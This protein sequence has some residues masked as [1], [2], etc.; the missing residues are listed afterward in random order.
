MVSFITSKTTGDTV[1]PSEWNQT[2]DINNLV[3]QSGITP[4]TG[5]LTQIGQAVSKYAAIST[6]YT[7]SGTAN[8]YVLTSI[9]SFESS[10][11]YTNGMIIRFRAANANTGAST[12]NVSGLGVVNI[13]KSDGSTDPEANDINTNFDTYARYDGTAFRLTSPNEIGNLNVA[14][15]VNFASTSETISS[16][17]FTYSSAYTALAA[18]GGVDDDLVT[19][20][21]GSQ[22]DILVIQRAAPG[23]ITIKSGTGNIVLRNG[24][25]RV[26]SVA[27]DT[28]ALV[29]DNTNWVPFGLESSQDFLSSKNTNGYTYLPNGL[30][31][32]W[33]NNS[34]T[35]G[36]TVT[37]PV[38]FG[39][40]F[41]VA[42]TS[43]RGIAG[44]IDTVYNRSGLT[45]ITLYHNQGGSIEVSWIAIGY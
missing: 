24:T 2:A 22:G 3:S 44:N 19:I 6:F 4:S 28:I 41:R 5:D 39:T 10:D 21:G 27:G 36:T 9:D 43:H 31:F 25:D 7:D 8:A 1:A 13:K 20:N 18:E 38:A 11:A 15:K 29:K 40:A 34:V 16:G 33:G 17:A 42:T 26:L 32:Q 23:N 12:V 30:I 35:S 37:L 45:G 14:N